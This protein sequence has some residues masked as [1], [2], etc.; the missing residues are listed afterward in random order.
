MAQRQAVKR[1]VFSMLREA[2]PVKISLAE[3]DRSLKTPASHL[4]P[5]LSSRSFLAN[6]LTVNQGYRHLLFYLKK[7]M[8]YF[9]VVS[10]AFNWAN[11]SLLDF[12]DY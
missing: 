6:P 2:K 5:S 3:R 9:S 8:V 7:R 12:S 1:H 10:I 4:P 11:C